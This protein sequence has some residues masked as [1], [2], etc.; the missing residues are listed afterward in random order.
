[1][2]KWYEQVRME[3]GNN[4]ISS[5][6]RL[7]RNCA[8]QC[9]P[10]RLKGQDSLRLIETMRTRLEDIGAVEGE[11]MSSCLLSDLPDA[12]RDAMRERRVLNAGILQKK[13]PVGLMLSE[14]ED[15]SLVLNGDDHFRLQVLAPN[16]HL[17]ELW[18]KAGR[19]DD[20]INERFSY[21]FDDRYGYLTSFP[22][23]VGTGM[24]AN[25]VV[26][27]PALSTGKQ[28]PNL[29]ASMNRFG[30]TVRGVYGTGKENYGALYDVSNAKTL[31]MS[32]SAVANKLRLLRLTPE[33]RE[34]VMKNRL[35]EKHAR[36]FVR[37]D[38]ITKRGE[39]MRRAALLG[40]S[41]QE[42]DKK[43]S[44]LFVDERPPVR[45]KRT[46]FR[47]R[48][49]VAVSDIGMFINS[50]NNAVRIAH[51]VGVDVERRDVET[52]DSLE[53]IIT[54]PKKSKASLTARAQAAKC[55]GGNVQ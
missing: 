49:V 52:G 38:D 51:D 5:R 19:L 42:T 36:A 34:F 43:V 40:W 50:I 18:E 16:S 20:Y 30:V 22:T 27:L 48:R 32:Q 29:L 11:T 54:V 21:A 24:R 13:T 6:I 1:M 15:I 4:Y 46:G 7:V 31:G 10:N 3:P 25:I 14:S 37:V 45:E 55:S 44:A 39:I 47:G 2:E 28:F 26:H 35:T 8:D 53:I 17:Y 12:A 33:E 9:F 23:N 41:S